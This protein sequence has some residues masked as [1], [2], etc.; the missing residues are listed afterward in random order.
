MKIKTLVLATAMFAVATS[1]AAAQSNNAVGA[2]SETKHDTGAAKD[3]MVSKDTMTKGQMA[4]DKM[5]QDKL[6]KDQMNG[7]SSDVSPA[8]PDAGIK[9]VK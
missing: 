7:K 9:Q 3:N 1:F 8:A 4:K 6:S 5:T 2:A